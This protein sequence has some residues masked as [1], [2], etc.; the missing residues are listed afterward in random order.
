MSLVSITTSLIIIDGITEKPAFE[1]L[2]AW[3]SKWVLTGFL[4]SAL[5]LLVYE[6]V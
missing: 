1:G 5:D 3:V 6:L 4:E 2:A